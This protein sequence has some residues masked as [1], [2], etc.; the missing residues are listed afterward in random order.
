[1]DKEKGIFNDFISDQPKITGSTTI[2]HAVRVK[3]GITADEYCFMMYLE[4]RKNKSRE[5]D[6]SH[7]F[8]IIG[9]N[10]NMAKLMYH[11]LVQHGFLGLFK[12]GEVPKLTE[13]WGQAFNVD[14]EF[15]Q[16]WTV[17]LPDG[18][19]RTAWPG[20]K[21]ATRK[22]F[23]KVRK[24]YSLEY[25]LRQRDHYFKFLILTKKYRNFDRMK[26][27]GPVWLGPD[28][29]YETDWKSEWEELE[30][31][32]NPKKPMAEAVTIESVKK[33]YNK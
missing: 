12:P 29:H 14:F 25:I 21:E 9:Y 23:D 26:M 6:L 28:K 4:E 24:Q 33:A 11:G 22:L 18:K 3:L 30:E 16:F 19:K 32:Y 27:G 8:S 13:R 1:M 17:N 2:N 31:K 20:S 7:C 10:A 5:F 15:N